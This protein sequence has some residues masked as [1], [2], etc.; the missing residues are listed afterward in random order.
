VVYDLTPWK[1]QSVY[2]Y[3]GAF[4]DGNGGPSSTRLYVD[5]VQVVTCR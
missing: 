4:N 5:D 3:F 2:L 1:G